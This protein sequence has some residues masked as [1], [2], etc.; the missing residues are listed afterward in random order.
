MKMDAISRLKERQEAVVLAHN[1]QDAAVQEVADLVGDSLELSRAAAELDCKA[2]VFAG[3]DFMAQTAAILSPEK[4]VVLTVANA[5]CPMAHMIKAKD[6]RATK[7]LHPE[8][9]VVCYVNST[10]DVKAESDIC[11][12]SANGVEVV[13]SMEQDQIIFVP[14][15]NLAAFVARHTSKEIIPGNGFCYAHDQFTADMVREAKAKHPNA[16]VLVHPECR[17]EVIDLADAVCSTSG[18]IREAQASDAQEFIIGTEV[19]MLHPLRAKMPGKEFHPLFTKAIC[20]DM[21]KTDLSRVRQALETL[22]PRVVVPEPVASKA[23]VAIQRML[24]L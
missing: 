8:A 10:A 20:H 2:I 22:E 6:L 23:R 21:K 19:G 15:R 3:V 5:T 14:D 24:D 1:Y 4:R 13:N 9:G 11:C 7:L 18:M 17:A 16:V 12:T